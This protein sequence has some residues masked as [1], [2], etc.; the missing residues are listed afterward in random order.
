MKRLLFIFV[1][2]GCIV[3]MNAQQESRYTHSMFTYNSINPGSVG[4]SELGDASLIGRQQNWGF[5]S[6]DG[7]SMSPQS[8]VVNFSMPVKRF[9]SGIGFSISTYQYGFESDITPKLSYSYQLKLGDGKLG[10]GMSA[11]LIFLG[12]DKE[13]LR[14]EDENDVYLQGIMATPDYMMLDIGCGVHYKVDRAYFGVSSTRLNQPKLKADTQD[15]RY[16]SRH[17]YIYSGYTYPTNITGLILKPS[18]FVR[19]TGVSATSG[20]FNFV[21]EY[22]NL[23]YGGLIYS[24]NNDISVL[25]G[26]EFKDGS[27]FDG[28]RV[29]AS[30]DIFTNSMRQYSKGSFEVM[31]GY[32]FSM[33]VEKSTKSYKSVRFL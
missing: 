32:S 20:S 18:V 14:P 15:Y 9:S 33:S 8:A 4:S 11:G 31:I 27:K 28:M 1:L 3:R 23:F 22:N 13:K 24:T 12:F 26:I 30:Y 2:L 29:G 5:K 21:G 6:S 17:F 7:E 25:G 10:F 19:S 16:T